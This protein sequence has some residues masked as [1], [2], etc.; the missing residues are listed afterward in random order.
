M[1][2]EFE[3]GATKCDRAGGE[4]EGLA[5]GAV[6]AHVDVDGVEGRVDDVDGTRVQLGGAAEEVVDG[7]FVPEVRPGRSQPWGFDQEG[8]VS[9]S[10][11]RRTR[12]R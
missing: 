1:R 4:A 2:G 11:K 10:G 6:A 5:G 3:V 12:R 7:A 9:G 8:D